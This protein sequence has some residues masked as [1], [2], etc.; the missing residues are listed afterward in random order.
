MASAAARNE[1]QIRMAP[2]ATHGPA[3]HDTAWSAALVAVTAAGDH[4]PPPEVVVRTRP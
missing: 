2:T 3:P 4:V 1:P